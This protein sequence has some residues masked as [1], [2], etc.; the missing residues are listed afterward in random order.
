M[1]SVNRYVKG[2]CLGQRS[3]KS[4][5]K[6]KEDLFYFVRAQ[7][8][9]IYHLI[10]ISKYAS[11]PFQEIRIQ[12]IQKY[13]SCPSSR[14]GSFLRLIPEKNRNNRFLELGRRVQCWIVKYAQIPSKPEQNW[15]VTLVSIVFLLLLSFLLGL[16]FIILKAKQY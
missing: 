9:L 5:K 1:L 15:T 12:L 6:I 10:G 16:I 3:L 7:I 14:Q 8:V 11:K 4:E 13:L 2:I